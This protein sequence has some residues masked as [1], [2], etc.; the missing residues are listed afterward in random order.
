LSNCQIQKRTAA[1]VLRL[2]MHR[3]DG[4]PDSKPIEEVQGCEEIIQEA[5]TLN[6]E[7]IRRIV[8]SEEYCIMR[9]C[10]AL[11]ICWIGIT[12]VPL[13]AEEPLK[14]SG[15]TMGSYYAIVIDSPGNAD[16]KT[17]RREIESKFADISRQMS[18]WDDQSEISRFNRSESTEWFAV[19]Y[20]FATVVQEAS[21]LYQ[22]TEGA[23]DVTVTPL[24]DVWGFGREKRRLVPSE[25]EIERARKSVG[26]KHVEVRLEPPALR[27]HLPAL[28]LNLSSLA[29]GYAADEVCKMLDSHRL[30]AHVVDVGGENRAGEAKANGDPWRLGV[31]SPLGGLHK[32]IE[33]T[34]HA[35][36]TSGDYR[37]FFVSGGKK[38][39]HV[40]NPATGR[41][42][43]NP[44]ASVSVIHKSCMTAD[45]LAT[46]MMVLGA[47]RGI[48]IARQ[49][50]VDVMFLDVDSGGR[51][52]EISVGVFQQPE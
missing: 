15:K 26:M 51:L 35:I 50:G 39:A 17:L 5:T 13:I 43:E 30:K 27:K 29:P 7:R 42:V 11:V 24:L 32:V 16:A 31:E 9:L 14:I 22:M 8:D 2:K 20:D 38:Y 33:L 44:P 45:G 18:N 19:S 12:E 47:E 46:A 28:Q 4:R 34:N 1:P 6:P 48:E 36:A 52:V 23:I 10:F 40:L 37:S 21:R 49:C 41:P 3:S 25:E